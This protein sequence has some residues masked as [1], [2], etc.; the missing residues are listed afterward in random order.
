MIEAS[1]DRLEELIKD[2]AKLEL[3]IGVSLAVYIRN[4]EHSFFTATPLCPKT[5]ILVLDSKRALP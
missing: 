3:E 2:A 1:C 5:P 4:G